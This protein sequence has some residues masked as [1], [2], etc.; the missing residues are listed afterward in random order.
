LLQQGSNVSGK[1]SNLQSSSRPCG[2]GHNAGSR[3]MTRA[4]CQHVGSNCC[5]LQW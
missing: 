5:S 1:L 2:L 4:Y 3:Q